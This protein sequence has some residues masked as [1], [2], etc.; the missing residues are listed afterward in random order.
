V[1]TPVLKTTR[2]SA[3]RSQGFT[4]I[5]L[6][7]A[8]VVVAIVISVGVPSLNQ[9]IESSRASSDVRLLTN[10]LSTARSEAIVRAQIITVSAEGGK[11]VDGWRSWQDAD[12]DGNLDSGE[13]VK[14]FAGLESN[15]SLL[16]DRNGSAV[17]SV[18]FNSDGF[19][20]GTQAV[21][22]A[23]RTSPEHCSRDRNIQISLSGQVRV[24]ERNCP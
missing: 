22:F 13:T 2:F 17:S 11:W 20:V 12:A 24:T 9:F 6:L 10:S 5:E 21:V 3:Q 16:A 15:A 18:A 8:M 1:L 14:R 23:Y 19:L 7:V 4:L